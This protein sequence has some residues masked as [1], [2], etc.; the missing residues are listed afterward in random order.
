MQRVWAIGAR[1]G[2]AARSLPSRAYKHARH[3]A[4]DTYESWAEACTMPSRATVAR[5]ARRGAAAAAVAG[6]G[7]AAGMAGSDE[8]R[9]LVMARCEAGARSVLGREGAWTEARR[10]LLADARGV[11]LELGAGTGATFAALP[12]GAYIEYAACEENPHAMP[13][14]LE[15]AERHGFPEPF[16]EL[17]REGAEEF[18]AARP[19]ASADAVIDSGGIARAADPAAALAQVRRVLRPGGRLYFVETVAQP[20]AGAP[21]GR[22]VQAAAAPVLELF[23]GRRPDALSPAVFEQAGFTSLVAQWWPAEMVPEG[24]AQPEPAE[25]KTAGAGGDTPTDV[26][27]YGRR[28]GLVAPVLAG[29]A[30]QRLPITAADAAEPLGFGSGAADLFGFAL[31]DGGESLRV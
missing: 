18:L 2:A 20:E 3:I 4:K 21:L 30:T 7:L 10:A 9:M 31:P 27:Y 17:R 12:R 26:F 8:V 5:L 19:D 14:L 6:A 13:L 25:R 29:V 23:T 22:A 11:V 1:A 28:S 15:E 16:T 24:G